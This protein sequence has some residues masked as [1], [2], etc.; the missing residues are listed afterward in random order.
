MSAPT[1]TTSS[2]D[3]GA[4]ARAEVEV[5]EARGAGVDLAASAHAVDGVHE[6]LRVDVEL[7]RAGGRGGDVREVRR[8]AADDDALQ[9]VG[10]GRG[11]IGLAVAGRVDREPGH[12][13]ADLGPRGGTVVAQAR[14]ARV[15]IQ[16]ADDAD[17]A[18]VVALTPAGLDEREEARHV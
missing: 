13:R 11:R 17:A 2:G 7:Q 1:A 3:P 5:E 6:R 18:V 4:G 10:E 12:A 14:G 15:E 9:L 16:P 8:V